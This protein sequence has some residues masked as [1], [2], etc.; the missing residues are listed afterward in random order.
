M[1]EG[2]RRGKGGE[3]SDGGGLIVGRMCSP[4]VGVGSVRPWGDR[5]RPWV[6]VSLLSL[7]VVVC[8][9]WVVVCGG[10]ATFVVL[11][12]GWLWFEAGR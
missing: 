12:G 9:R 1:M 8:G 5:G 3:G 7:G 11:R 2:G 4:I 6:G 10:W